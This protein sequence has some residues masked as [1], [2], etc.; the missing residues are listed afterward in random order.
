MKRSLYAVLLILCLLLCACSTD[1]P[2]TMAS[3]PGTTASQPQSTPAPSQP[4]PGPTVL[5]TQPTTVPEPD[6][7]PSPEFAAMPVMYS[8]AVDV[9]LSGNFAVFSFITSGL[10]SA[11]VT[12]VTYDILQDALLGQLYLGDGNFTVFMLEGERFAVV[13]LMEGIYSLYNAD[14]TLEYEILLEGVLTPYSFAGQLGDTLLLCESLTGA[15][16]LYDIP[17]AEITAVDLWPDVYWYIGAS[18]EGFLIRSCYDDLLRIS[19]DGAV[20]I[21]FFEAC[22]QVAGSTYAA[23]IE[24]DYVELLKLDGSGERLLLDQLGES[25]IF[26]A[27]DGAG[28]LSHSQG[29]ELSDCL[30]YYDMD[31]MT[32]S[33]EPAGGG[34]VGA[35]LDADRALVVLRTD[36]SDPL[37]FLYLEFSG[38]CSQPLIP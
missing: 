8:D 12:V 26:A 32:V 21:L 19:P 4:Q 23:A 35:A 34:V 38:S 29:M 16:Y 14:C 2:P 33:I 6:P 7:Y 5:P 36:Y 1:V 15:L 37:C 30:Y 11:E 17:S 31:A 24:G 3:T 20:E 9:Q 10:D 27:A 25:E 18:G 28:L 22:T 13:D